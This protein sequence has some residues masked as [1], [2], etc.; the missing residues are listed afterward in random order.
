MVIES[1]SDQHSQTSLTRVAQRLDLVFRVPLSLGT[2]H[3]GIQLLS[4]T[5]IKYHHL[6]NVYVQT[7][8]LRKLIPLVVA[9]SSSPR[10]TVEASAIIRRKKLNKRGSKNVYSEIKVVQTRDDFLSVILANSIYRITNHVSQTFKELHIQIVLK[11]LCQFLHTGWQLLRLT[12]CKL[13]EHLIP[14][15]VRL[16]VIDDEI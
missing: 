7:L 10:N 3:H 12:T 4:Q 9:T 8:D 15:V 6:S 13:Y 11:I 5:E 14:L 2:V 16:L 1:S